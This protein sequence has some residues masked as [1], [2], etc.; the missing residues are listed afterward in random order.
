MR[1]K[2]LKRKHLL[3]FE[4]L[5]PRTMMAITPVIPPDTYDTFPFNNDT[6]A[7]AADFGQ[8][9]GQLVVPNLTME[10]AYDWFAFTMPLQADASS[11]VR[12]NFLNSQGDLDLS[13]YTPRGTR[14]RN[15]AT[16]NDVETFSI[17]NLAAGQYF[18]RVAGFNRA[19]NPNYT[20]TIKTAQG[21]IIDPTVK[22]IDVLGGLLNV[23]DSAL[24]GKEISVQ[25]KVRNNGTSSTGN[26]VS[27]SYFLSRDS[28]ISADDI[29]L[30]LTN[31]TG[32][33]NFPAVGA[34]GLSSAKNVRLTLPEKLPDGWSGSFF[35]IVQS[36]DAPNLIAESNEKN[37]GGQAGRQ[38]D[39]E[40]ISIFNS[41]ET[42]QNTYFDI[43]INPVGMTPQ[44]L[45]Y[46]EL[47]A[48]RWERIIIGDLPNV[49]TSPGIIVD[50]LAITASVLQIDGAGGTLA[51]AT[52]D[53]RRDDSLGGLPATGFMEFDAADM[54]AMEGDGTLLDVITHEMGHVLGIG[55]LWDVFGLIQGEFG[56]YPL[57]TGAKGVAGF[58]SISGL[59]PVTSFPIEADGG[60]GT[61]YGHW[62]ELLMQTELMTGFSGPGNF[63]AISAVT[64]GSLADMG[65]K[66]NFAAAEKYLLQSQ[67]T[68]RSL[69]IPYPNLPVG[70]P[71]YDLKALPPPI[72]VLAKLSPVSASTSGKVAGP[73]L[74][75]TPS[76]NSA[77]KLTS[78]S[79]AYI[80]TSAVTNS[81][82]VD[83]DKKA[84]SSSDRKDLDEIFASFGV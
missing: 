76:E 16:I 78:L 77:S 10:D 55:S 38:L 82:L 12:I 39:W 46:F 3:S 26:G 61:A 17:K 53:V 67:P 73:A 33:V 18:V 83:R 74:P 84:A 21:P 56:P 27:V 23:D 20:L 32:V 11:F 6:L 42:P 5:E 50:D 72:T 57:Y 34:K 22:T 70:S 43:K 62:D 68:P 48:K 58:N 75:S 31:F 37:N 54:H 24:W 30:P 13:L 8:F 4:K 81:S 15:S 49:Q 69:P 41:L 25:S 60:P 35:Y 44:Q 63:N 9:S 51:Q 64:V 80:E 1:N 14:I 79:S 52:W 40:P 36:T 65:Y 19:P 45:Q 7:T 29:L 47:A 66:V 59:A 28:K 2:I 71:G